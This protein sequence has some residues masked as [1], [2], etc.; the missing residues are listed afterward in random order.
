MFSAGRTAR[1]AASHPR[2][3]ALNVLRDLPQVADLIELCFHKSMD[4]DGESYLREMRRAA[5]EPS[6]FRSAESA[7]S[8][9]LNGFV[10]EENGKIVGNASLIS[11]RH[12]R[13]RIHMLANIAV[14]PDFRRRGIARAVTERAMEQAR[15]RGADE[16]WLNVRDDNPDAL[17]LYADLGF[18][19][20]GRRVAWLST[21]EPRPLPPSDGFAVLP[22]RPDF[23]PRQRAWLA[24]SYPDELAWYRAWDFKPLAPGLWNWLHLLF[25]DVNLRQWAAT[26][27]GS[28]EAVLAWISNGTRREPLWLAL[29]A[30]SAPEAATRLLVHA[31]SELRGRRFVLEHPAGPADESIRAAGFIPQRTLVWMRAEGA[32]K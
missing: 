29:G 17:D 9:P 32:T 26:R 1:R 20:R 11:Y 16:L 22:R 12:D 24:R 23:W 3:R 28:L 27:N 6:W 18:V 25:V 2:L 8:V 10:W 5:S 13:K 15:Q 21:E 7:S 31:R 14:H 30:D 4:A 19:E